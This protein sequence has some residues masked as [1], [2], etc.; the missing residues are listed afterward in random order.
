MSFERAYAAIMA[1]HAFLLTRGLGRRGKPSQGVEDESPEETQG[2][3][4]GEDEAWS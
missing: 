1:Y 2:K 3:D 4:C